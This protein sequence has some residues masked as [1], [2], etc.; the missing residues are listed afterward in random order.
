MLDLSCL[1]PT[2]VVC[3]WLQLQGFT[4]VAFLPCVENLCDNI[5][6]PPTTGLYGLSDLLSVVIPEPR[7][8]SMHCG[9]PSQGRTLHSLLRSAV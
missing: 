7:G 3:M 8:E 9:C 5:P 1:D 2:Q 6:L 4:S